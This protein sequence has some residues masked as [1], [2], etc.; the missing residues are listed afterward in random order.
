MSAS[1]FR[2]ATD[3]TRHA[4]HYTG[5]I[6]PGWDIAGAANGGYLIALGAHALLHATDRSDPVSVTAHFLSPGTPGPVEISTE[7]IRSGRRFSTAAG[8][9]ARDGRPL[10]TLLGT[11]GDLSQDTE[12]LHVNG[13]PPLLP[14]PDDC[15]PLVATDT[16][17][18]PFMDQ[19]ELRLHPQDAA[20]L[21][22]ANAGRPQMNGWFRLRDGEEISTLSL[23]CALDS[24]PPAIFNM[25][26]PIAWTPTIE[27]TT[28]IRARPVPGWLRCRFSTKFITGGFLE[29]DGEIW[30][31]DGQLVAQSRQ[32]A[33][34]PR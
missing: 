28:H 2:L 11:F 27:L 34:L 12:P 26:L 17:P 18:P 14:P 15:I 22:G 5:D 16:F 8:S 3:V 19:V 6:K 23:L 7:V 21:S 24:F 4:D 1:R 29:E 33:L 9:M 32:L 13:R 25:D 20:F 31:Q 10:L 30:D